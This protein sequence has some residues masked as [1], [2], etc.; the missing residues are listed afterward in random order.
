MS[1]FQALHNQLGRDTTHDGVVGL[2]AYPAVA[3]VFRIGRV[4]LLVK[5]NNVCTRRAFA[6]VDWH[7]VGCLA[8][9]VHGAFARTN[10]L[11]CVAHIAGCKVCQR[12]VCDE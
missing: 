8:F 6:F 10:C 1:A 2:N 12:F 5:A 11:E 9:L 3:R 4:W 7:G